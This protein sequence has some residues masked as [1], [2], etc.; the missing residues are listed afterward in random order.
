MV[1]KDSHGKSA[2]EFIKNGA[3][4]EH[5]EG[6]QNSSRLIAHL[7]KLS[8]RLGAGTARN[9]QLHNEIKA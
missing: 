4:R 9:E 7:G 3:S 1:R 5:Y 2:M 8:E 6:L